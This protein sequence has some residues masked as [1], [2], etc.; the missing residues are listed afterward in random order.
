MPI[1]YVP[2]K[3]F[4]NSYL[5]TNSQ[6]PKGSLWSWRTIYTKSQQHNTTNF[7]ASGL[8]LVSV[9]AP[10][11]TINTLVEKENLEYY[12]KYEETHGE[13]IMVSKTVRRAET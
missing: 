12:S 4:S 1:I 7:S 5:G 10:A 6:Q 13:G 9:D 8:E 2:L 11:A 3:R